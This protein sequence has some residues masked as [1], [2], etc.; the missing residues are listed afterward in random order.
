MS[1]YPELRDK[2]AL[3]AR[4]L[5]LRLDWVEQG[6]SGRLVLVVSREQIVLARAFLAF[7]I[8]PAIEARI[9][10]DLEPAFG[11]DWNL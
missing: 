10:A 6:K 8:T 4:T 1:S 5:G 7:R 9:V 2:I 3:A 11:K